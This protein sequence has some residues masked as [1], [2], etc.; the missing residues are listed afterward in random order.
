MMKNE[1]KLTWSLHSQLK[2]STNNAE[3]TIKQLTSYF[4]ELIP[5]CDFWIALEL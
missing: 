3:V 1:R 5:I 4:Q 2:Q